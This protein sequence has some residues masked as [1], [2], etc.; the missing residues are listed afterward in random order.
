MLMETRC[1][2]APPQPVCSG[3]LGTTLPATILCRMRRASR[4]SSIRLR[5]AG[6]EWPSPG[7]ATVEGGEDG[8]AA[9]GAV[10]DAEDAEDVEVVVDGA[11]GEAEGEMEVGK[12]EAPMETLP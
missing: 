12:G 3:A 10:E 11:E 1:T 6:K 2:S 5:V 7:T 4:T 8:A 9:V